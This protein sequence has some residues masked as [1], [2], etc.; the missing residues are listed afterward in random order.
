MQ[1][2]ATNVVPTVYTEVRKLRKQL[3]RERLTRTVCFAGLMGVSFSWIA[4]VLTK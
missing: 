3:R 1:E 2:Q 4:E